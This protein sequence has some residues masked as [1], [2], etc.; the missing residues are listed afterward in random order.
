MKFEL[1]DETVEHNGIPLFRIKALKSFASVRE[2]DKGGYVQ[3]LSNLSQ[4]GDSWIFGEAKVYDRAVISQN[5][6]IADKAEV[7]GDALVSGNAHVRNYA[8]VSG[9]L[10]I[11]DSVDICSNA[12]VSGRL[13]LSGDIIIGKDAELTQEGDFIS[14]SNYSP[15]NT[16][17]SAYRDKT[18]NILIRK[19]VSTYSLTDVIP[20]SYA[21]A[22]FTHETIVWNALI[23]FLLK[24]FNREVKHDEEINKKVYEN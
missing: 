7:C 15:N 14:I 12:Y 1:T 21:H 2:G 18:G 23:D 8:K 10:I 4:E 20:E 16:N 6:V 17:I 19:G 24:Y 22:R 3:S 11:T 13:Y 5:A 9:P